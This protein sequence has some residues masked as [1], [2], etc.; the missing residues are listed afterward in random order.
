[1][2]VVIGRVRK[3]H[4]MGGVKFIALGHNTIRGA[5]G[6]GILNAECLKVKIHLKVK[7]VEPGKKD[8]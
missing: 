4:V 3:D 1:M 8:D 7:I 6:V 5:A 2:S